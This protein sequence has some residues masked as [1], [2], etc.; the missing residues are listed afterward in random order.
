MSG[1]AAGALAGVPDLS[2]YPQ[3][4]NSG[5][6][7]MALASHVAY[8]SGSAQVSRHIAASGTGAGEA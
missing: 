2:P 7:P 3:R 5:T 8:A 4:L 1:V 6:H